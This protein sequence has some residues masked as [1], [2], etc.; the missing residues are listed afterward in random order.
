MRILARIA[1]G[2]VRGRGRDAV[3]IRAEAS[4]LTREGSMRFVTACA[5]VT[6]SVTSLAAQTPS[7]QPP[8]P[9]PA[10]P[11]ALMARLAQGAWNNA[12]RDIVESADQIDRKSVV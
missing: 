12:K 8:A 2:L 9:R 7:P 11:G 1:L 3:G 10:T 5:V 6:L 4:V